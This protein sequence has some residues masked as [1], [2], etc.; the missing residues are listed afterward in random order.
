MEPELPRLCREKS[1]THKGMQCPG[2]KMKTAFQEA[3][4][5]QTCQMLLQGRVGMRIS[6][7]IQRVNLTKGT[8]AQQ[9]RLKVSKERLGETTI[10][11]T[12]QSAPA[13]GPFHALVHPSHQGAYHLIQEAFLFATLKQAFHPTYS[14]PLSCFFEIVH[15]THTCMCAYTHSSTS[16]YF[17]SIALFIC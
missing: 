2:G 17:K 1:R 15:H 11:Q 10:S 8:S 16:Q 12:F 5:I 7:Y 4:S 9:L 3:E 6:N 14:R 13:T